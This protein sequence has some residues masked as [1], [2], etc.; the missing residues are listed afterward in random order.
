M[1]PATQERSVTLSVAQQVPKKDID[2][3]RVVLGAAELS[4][5]AAKRAPRDE[6]VVKQEAKTLI[7]GRSWVLQ[8]IGRLSEAAVAGEKSL[9]IGENIPWPRNTAYCRKCLGRL[10]RLQAENS[11]GAER[12]R[13]LNESVRYLKAAADLF[14]QLGESDSMAERGDSLSLPADLPVEPA[15]RD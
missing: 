12:R 4:I 5:S 6:E 9:E 15:D 10:F 7:C 11:S 2:D 13:L 3:T 1:S 14:E 8:R